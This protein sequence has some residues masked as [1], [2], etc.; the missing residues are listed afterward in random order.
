MKIVERF[1]RKY[2][3][4]ML[5]IIALF[6]LLN[7]VL[8][9]GVLIWAWQTSETPML[10]INEI[11]DSIMVDEEGRFAAAEGL[12]ELLEEHQTWVMLLD[13][14][15]AVIFESGLPEELPRQYT[16][17]DTAV[18]LASLIPLIPG[19]LSQFLRL[20]LQQRIQRFFHAPA[21]QLLK[22]TLDYFFI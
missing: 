14:T 9:F 5:G 15:G 12:P 20:L 1:F 18:P 13:E 19:C 16:A 17:A 11:C 2:F 7:I 6:L 10:S 21:N 22:L 8:S 3:L 4:S